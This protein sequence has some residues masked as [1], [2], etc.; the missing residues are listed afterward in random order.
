MPLLRKKK[1][2]KLPG[3]EIEQL[4]NTL[5]VMKLER[6]KVKASQ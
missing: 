5:I 3:M 2:N 6:P 1:K 4:S